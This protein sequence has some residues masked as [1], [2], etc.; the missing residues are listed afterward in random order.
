MFG[1]IYDVRRQQQADLEKS[2][3]NYASIP[4]G[5]VSV[6]GAAQA[7][8]MLGSGIGELAGLQTPE[9]ARVSKL[10]E[11]QAQ[12]AD[13]D[14]SKPENIKTVAGE[15]LRQGFS[16]EA[17]QAY[18]MIDKMSSTSTSGLK[19]DLDQQASALQ[20]VFIAEFGSL[21]NIENL[22][23]FKK[24]LDQAGLGNTT[25]YGRVSADLRTLRGEEGKITKEQRGSMQDLSKEMLKFNLPQ[26]ETEI[27]KME[28]L[29][30]EFGGNL[31]G[32]NILEEYDPR[33]DAKR[34]QSQYAR[35]RNIVLKER[36]GAAVTN[37][38]FERLREEIRG[39]T[40][41]TD[42]DVIR[43]TQGLREALES[44]KE[45]VFSGFTQDVRDLYTKGGGTKPMSEGGLTQEQQSI[46]DKYK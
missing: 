41:V 15:L 37:P 13:L 23:K 8:G 29:I 4:R 46:I 17:K 40:F 26:M 31:P 34:V 35:L 9:Q 30:K 20:R 21:D 32:I 28:S 10:Q 1:N 3:I 12:F 24:Q 36:S 39:A 7:G 5:R 33:S 42:A 45:A 14:L 22:K 43:W 18:D 2:A 11:I 25:L 19:F 44:N 27:N 38:E 6:A 16:Q